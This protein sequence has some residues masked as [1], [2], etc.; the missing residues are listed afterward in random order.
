MLRRYKLCFVAIVVAVTIF[1]V[2]FPLDS[3]R[4]VQ[5]YNS[6]VMGNVVSAVVEK[7]KLNSYKASLLGKT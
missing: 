7:E 3:M 6:G 1:L 4:H 5:S 2:F